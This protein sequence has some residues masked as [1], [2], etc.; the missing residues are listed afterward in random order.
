M[1]NTEIRVKGKI[2]PNWSDWFG[3]LH[4]QENPCDETIL[5]GKLPD[6]AAVYGVISHLGS[7]VIPLVS[8]NCFE[9]SDAD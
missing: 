1:Y 3:E 9:E 7:L 4:M 8:V 6:M 2:N 5:H